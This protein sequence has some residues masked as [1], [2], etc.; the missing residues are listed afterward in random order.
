MA[1][2]LPQ[3]GGFRADAAP[4]PDAMRQGVLGF[5]P[6]RLKLEA[7]H[8]YGRRG[9]APLTSTTPPLGLVS[10]VTLVSLW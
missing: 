7:Q 6:H 5:Q 1:D 4:H 9:V 3:C 2:T 10:P 8:T